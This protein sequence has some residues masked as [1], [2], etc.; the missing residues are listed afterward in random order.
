MKILVINCGSSS[1][2]YQLIAMDTEEV[3][4]KG[5]CERI[6]IEGSKLV[7]QVP[8]K[9]KFIFEKP[10]PN[11]EVAI[12]LVLEALTDKEYGVI[13]DASEI[14][15]VGHRVVQ[16]G[17][18]YPESVVID[19]EVKAE[20]K[21]YCDLA[22]LHNPANL[23]GIEAVEKAMPGITNVAAFDTSFGMGMPQ[24]AYKYAIPSEYYDKYHI[25]RY[26]FHGTSHM[27][28]SH[29]A[30]EFANLDKDSAKVIVCHLGNGASI[31]ASVGGKCV[32]SSMGLTPLEGLIMGT[33]SGDI[34]PAVI[35]F[36]SEKEKMSIK[37]I[38]TLLNKKSGVL[39]VS[40]VSSDF[41]DIEG[42]AEKGNDRARLALDMF[43]TR[44]KKYI[45]AY[46]AELEGVDA[47]VFTA[48]LGENSAESREEICKG[49]ESLGIE[50][51][52]DANKVRGKE[53]LISK[54]DSKIKI[55]VIPTNEELVIA[56]DTLEIV[57]K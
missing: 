52:V 48:G 39:G 51:D 5:L 25:R 43:H 6:Y 49:L 17:V 3:L 20:I 22:P 44:V 7:H 26:G 42:E 11:H 23:M 57:S 33:R 41:R 8:G 27:Y 45:G 29:E 46:M 35:P 15:A 32:D 55:Y 40:G 14:A 34:D 9:D 2:K 16:G 50:I 53:Q 31:S 38:D 4:A 19:D 36:L 24:K 10:M 13:K 47:I 30:V 37:E 21:K 1:L 12:Q 18:K 56:R 54:K 28:V